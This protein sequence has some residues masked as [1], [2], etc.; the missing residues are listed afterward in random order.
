[1]ALKTPNLC[2]TDLVQTLNESTHSVDVKKNRTLGKIYPSSPGKA[3][4]S[5][6]GYNNF[7][8]FVLIVVLSHLDKST[9]FG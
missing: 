6:G 7:S 3:K 2:G 1:M 5:F 8:V 4:C 9:D